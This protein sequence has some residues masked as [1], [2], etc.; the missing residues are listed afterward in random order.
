M[1]FKTSGGSFL[2]FYRFDLPSSINT[3][4][5]FTTLN[6][7]PHRKTK[8]S[9]YC[10]LMLQSVSLAATLRVWLFR[11]SMTIVLLMLGPH[12]SKIRLMSHLA[13][14]FYMVIKYGDKIRHSA[15]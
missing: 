2:D 7:H 8:T 14:A 6:E 5:I 9:R 4:K 12:N 1:K 11:R 13:N 15:K 3:S 10:F